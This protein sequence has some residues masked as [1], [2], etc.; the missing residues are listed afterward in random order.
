MG[1]GRNKKA[2]KSEAAQLALARLNDIHF[3]NDTGMVNTLVHCHKTLKL[4]HAV[5]ALNHI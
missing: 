2:A 3:S 1:E 5:C 4:Y